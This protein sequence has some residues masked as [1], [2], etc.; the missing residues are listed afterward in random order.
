MASISPKTPFAW[1][2]KPSVWS[3]LQAAKIFACDADF[4]LMVWR[5]D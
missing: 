5:R 3:E 1:R 2:A 4:Q